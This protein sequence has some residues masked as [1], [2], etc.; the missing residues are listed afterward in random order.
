MRLDVIKQEPTVFLLRKLWRF[1][2][3][4]HKFIVLYAAMFFVANLALLI[5]PAVFGMLVREVQLHGL[6][7]ANEARVMT[8]VACLLVQTWVFWC[9][10]GPARVIER[11]VAFQAE[12]NYRRYLLGCVLD[13]GLTW[14]GEHD[15]GD[16]IDKV[17]KA[18]DGMSAFGQ[19]VFRI[20]EV[21]VRLLG[22]VT[23]VCF[24]SPLIGGLA[25]VLVMISCAGIFQFD[26]HLVP[27]YRSLNVYN[28]QA[29]AKVFDALSNVTTAKILHIEQP[30]LEGVM[31]RYSAPYLLFRANA[32]LNEWKWFT[33]AV[34]FQAVAILPFAIYIY[35]A[36]AHGE[37]V[38]AGSLS[39]LYMYLSNLITVYFGFSSLYQEIAIHKHRVLNAAPI[40][41][42]RAGEYSPERRLMPTWE[43]LAVQDVRFS[44]ENS[45]AKANLCGVNLR[46]RRGE[47]IALVGESG[48]GKSTFL[49]VFHGMYAH[50]SGRL[51]FDAQAGIP[52]CFADVDLRTMLVP[53]EPE[54]FS[55]SIRENITLGV[56]CTDEQ[57]AEAARWATFD[58]V[59]ADLP[60]G[61]ESVINEKGVNLSGGQKQRLALTRALLFAAQKDIVL[62]DES[63]S[64]VDPH[65]ESIIYNNIW[66]A[67]EGKTVLACIHKLNLLKLFDRVVMFENGRITDQGTFDELLSRNIRFRHAWNEFVATQAARAHGYP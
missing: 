18:G 27:Q 25:F 29:S 37:N 48:A 20:I 30:L 34:C 55:A 22:G 56:D 39:T 24:F 35:R 33:G 26:K 8:I 42:A 40:E 2:A 54:V 6:S 44:Y 41:E 3:G 17:N 11:S 46:F 15:S 16:T 5:Q 28:N 38:D 7:V 21:I 9:M 57:L 1:S 65:N 47:R 4:N 12:M 14:H 61:L 19:S 36:I 53:Q 49:K 58:K 45:S 62:L 13:L 64:S 59:L 60:M 31:A 50:A 51:H 32:A 52:T 43:T 23:A 63:T 10:H 66:K 67:F